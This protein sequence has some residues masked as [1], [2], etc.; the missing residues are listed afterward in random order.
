MPSALLPLVILQE[1]SLFFSTLILILLFLLHLLCIS[2]DYDWR[3]TIGDL[4]LYIGYRS[5]GLVTI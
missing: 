2:V 5:V 4:L 3:C 1:Y